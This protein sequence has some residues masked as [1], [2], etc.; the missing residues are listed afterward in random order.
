M[1][2]DLK[3]VPPAGD[4]YTEEPSVEC[5]LK[6]GSFMPL[7]LRTVLDL[8]G[9]SQAEFGGA[10]KQDGSNKTL[11]SSAVSNLLKWNRWL[12]KTSADSIK[13]Q[14]EA[15]L[16]DK[17]IPD[18]VIK[19]IWDEELDDQKRSGVAGGNKKTP[20]SL[21]GIN[22]GLI[23]ELSKTPEVV[24]LSQEAIRHF[25]L[26]KNPFK[27]EMNGSDDVFQSVEHRELLLA[28]HQAAKYNGLIAV[29]GESGG[30]KTEMKNELLRKIA[31]DDENII[32]IQPQNIN[33]KKTNSN[34]LLEA[35]IKTL[36]PNATVPISP[37]AKA[38][39]AIEELS[40]SSNLG[41]KHVLL[42]EE[43]HKHSSEIFPFYKQ[44]WEFQSGGDKL[45]GIVLIGHPELKFHLSLQHNWNSREFINRC[46]VA[47]LRPLDTSLEKYI[48]FKFSRIGT[49]ISEVV[50]KDV[51]DALRDVMWANPTGKKPV[52]ILH[53]LW[54]NNHLIKAM[55]LC[56]EIGLPLV[57][58]DAIRKVKL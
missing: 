7:V 9:I 31:R 8:Y 21:E 33:Q 10:I 20:H 41:N 57:N 34:S 55:N 47:E 45:L 17:G 35:I 1:K 30:G 36:N 51:Y 4:L 37:E 18:D 3:I 29:I 13:Q 12:K 46:E 16:K 50:D 24:M 25:K 53:P 22:A 39:K 14:A 6:G 23:D 2:P 44:L 42:Q 54:V 32:V 28:M 43:A 26:S 11:S 38:R 48:E 5:Q 58:A 52:S 49:P 15:F 56:A 40:A 27:Y 19:T